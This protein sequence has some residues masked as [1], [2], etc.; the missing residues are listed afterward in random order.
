MANTCVQKQWSQFT[1]VITRICQYYM[2][3]CKRKLCSY[4][5]KLPKIVSVIHEII[6][7]LDLERVSVTS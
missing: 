4:I 5:Q 3:H 2:I 1:N 7:D 6:V